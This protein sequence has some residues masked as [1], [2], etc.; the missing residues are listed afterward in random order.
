MIS[1]DNWRATTPGERAAGQKTDSQTK[2]YGISFGGPIIQDR[3]HFFLTY[4]AKRYETPTTV[5][6][7]G[8]VPANFVA[9]LPASASDQLGPATIGFDE[10]LFFAKVDWELTFNLGGALSSLAD[11][12]KKLK[13]L[14][15]VVDP[16][17]AGRPV[18]V[19]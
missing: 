9:A 4:E 11:P 7:G 5:L 15:L 3:M 14:V 8:G 2:E 18:K 10:D 16:P 19:P 6:P 12:G 13:T 17:V 1:D